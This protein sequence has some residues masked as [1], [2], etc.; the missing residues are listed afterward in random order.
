MAQ[1][2]TWLEVWEAD[3]TSLSIALS[4]SDHAILRDFLVLA[5]QD[6]NKIVK[7]IGV[8]TDDRDVHDRIYRNVHYILGFCKIMGLVKAAHVLAHADYLLDLGRKD[9]NF[10]RN[11]IDY[12]IKLSINTC[13]KI[14]YDIT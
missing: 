2:R 14:F 4:P 8:P 1:D 13:L 7:T 3:K 6:L 11:S 12:V 9:G 5:E 10:T